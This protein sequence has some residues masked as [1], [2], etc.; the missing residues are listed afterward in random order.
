MHLLASINTGTIHEVMVF[1]CKGFRTR[2]CRCE[3]KYQLLIH[4][5]SKS[6]TFI[7]EIV[8]C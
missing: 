6:T 7:I 4:Y 5:N 2:N 8:L 3:F 1:T